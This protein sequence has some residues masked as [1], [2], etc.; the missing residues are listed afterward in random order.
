MEKK[1]FDVQDDSECVFCG[2]EFDI[3]YFAEQANDLKFCPFC[4]KR[5]KVSKEGSREIERV[6]TLLDDKEDRR[7]YKS[8][9]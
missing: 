3:V 6:V 5:K 2:K 1:L 4:G 9:A 7:L 8:L